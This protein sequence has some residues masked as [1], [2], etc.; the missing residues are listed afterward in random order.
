MFDHDTCWNE[1]YIMD[2]GSSCRSWSRMSLT[3]P[4]TVHGT[5]RRG[6]A[7]PAARSFL[8]VLGEVGRGL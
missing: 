8:D 2:A 1:R 5:R 7:M 3:T 6:L 4:T